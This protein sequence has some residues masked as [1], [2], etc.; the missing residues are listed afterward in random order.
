MPTRILVL[1]AEPVVRSVIVEILKRGGYEVEPVDSVPAALE[2]VKAN[3]PNLLITNV[4]LPG[5]TGRDAVQLFK[6][7]CPKLRVLMVSGLPDTEVIQT[8]AGREG[9][10]TFPKPFLPQAL[11]E[12][13][14]AFLNNPGV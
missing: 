3:A 5:S 8:W 7:V 1:D 10:D 11:L 9:F 14:S 6:D 2:I 4:Y 12:K 13:V